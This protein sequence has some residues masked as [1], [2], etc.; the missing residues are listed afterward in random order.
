MKEK[1]KKLILYILL[2]TVTIV[3]VYSA[4]KLNENRIYNDTKTSYISSTLLEIKYEDLNSYLL[5]TTNSIIY[6]S[7]SSS[8][9]SIKFEKIFNKVIEDYE[10]EN[11]I[12]FININDTNIVDPL[13][14][15]APQLLFYK[16][17]EVFD[18]ID[19]NTLK[20]R[21]D[22]IKALEERSVID[23]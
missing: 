8:D 16:S 18:M 7:N 14:Q 22:I 21:K 4:I 20:D 13:Y 19:C 6:V 3:G 11:N 9:K 15:N 12:V 1:T 17:N 2:C 5:E 10:L 23:D